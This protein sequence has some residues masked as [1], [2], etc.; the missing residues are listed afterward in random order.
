MSIKQFIAGFAL[1]KA[2]QIKEA[3]KDI[4]ETIQTT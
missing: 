3:K 4:L 2:S 1:E